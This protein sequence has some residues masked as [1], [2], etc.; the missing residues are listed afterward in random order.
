MPVAPAAALFPDVSGGG[1]L[2]YTEGDGPKQISSTLAVSD[3]EGDSITGATVSIT[4][5]YAAGQDSL[6][7]TDEH[8]EARAV[9]VGV[10]HDGGFR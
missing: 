8:G 5:G 3:P 10:H 6:T 9:E 7:W 2:N 4:S 1:S